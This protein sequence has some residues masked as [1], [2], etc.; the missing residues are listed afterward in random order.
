MDNSLPAPA[1]EIPVRFDRDD[2]AKIIDLATAEHML[3]DWRK[4]NAAQFGYWLAAALT[5]VEPAKTARPAK[6]DGS[7]R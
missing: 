2:P 3:M 7:G 6:P 4:R 5:G 1:E